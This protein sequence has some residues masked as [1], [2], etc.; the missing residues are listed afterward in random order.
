MKLKIIALIIVI[1]LI[2]INFNLSSV[3]A[4]VSGSVGSL[5]SGNPYDNDNDG[6][7]DKPISEYSG[8]T[9]GQLRCNPTSYGDLCPDT[10]SG[11]RPI[12]S[13]YSN[14]GCGPSQT[15]KL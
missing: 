2:G 10:K 8:L 4:Q 5:D 6:I 12:G 1:L 14:S 9:Q 13:S 7:C 15:G 11:D 3:L